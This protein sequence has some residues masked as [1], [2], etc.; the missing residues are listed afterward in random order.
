M[1]LTL[2][3]HAVQHDNLFAQGVV[4]IFDEENPILKYIPMKPID[5]DAHKYRVEETMPGV[6]WRRVNQDYNE[7]TGVI[8]A[9]VEPLYIIGGETFMDNFILRTQGRG[10]GSYDHRRTQ[11]EMKA[12]GL[13]REYS[14]AFFEGDDLVDPDEMPGLRR[15]LTGSQVLLAGTNGAALTLAMIDELI[16]TVI[17]GNTHLFMNKFLRRK[18]TSLINQ[19]G[20]S[21]TYQITYDDVDS[22]G[23]QTMRYG[24]VPIHVIEDRGNQNTILGFDETAGSS[25]VTS[26]IYAV[27]FGDDEV[28]GIFAGDGPPVEVRDLGEDQ[29]SPGEK[30]R[31]EFFTGLVLKHPRAA[32]RLRGLLAS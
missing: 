30:G 14:R 16:D 15:R 7:S 29:D 19:G 12:R 28:Y 1:A 13:S 21:A 4:K 20:S 23:R 25:S 9:R 6:E 27:T 3:D 8:G 18:M 11:W 17:A 2:S 31:I 5:G 24:G 26:S 10:R 22:L 32:A